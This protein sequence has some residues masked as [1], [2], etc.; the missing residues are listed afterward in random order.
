MQQQPADLSCIALSQ[1]HVTHWRVFVE[2]VTAP[3]GAELLQ[4]MDP[5]RSWEA[6]DVEKGFGDQVSRSVAGTVHL[7]TPGSIVEAPWRTC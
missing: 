4:C 3:V 2:Q 7:S 1:L 5:L 6:T